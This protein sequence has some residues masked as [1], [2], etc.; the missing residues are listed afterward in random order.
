MVQ[1]DRFA[2]S[3]DPL[4]ILYVKSRGSRQWKEVG[5]TERIHNTLNPEWTQT[6]VL[7]YYF[8]EKQVS[9]FIIIAR[10]NVSPTLEF[11]PSNLDIV[12]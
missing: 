6:M 7:D 12:L 10:I 1:R 5:R 8:E 2:R 11:L 4:C 9:A 3:V